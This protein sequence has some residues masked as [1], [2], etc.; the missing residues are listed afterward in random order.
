[1]D[2]YSPGIHTYDSV[3]N[4][5]VVEIDRIA[6][7]VEQP[8]CHQKAVGSNPTPVISFQLVFRTS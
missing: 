6:Q 7:L 8:T 1:M 5:L 4:H 3:C 2:Y